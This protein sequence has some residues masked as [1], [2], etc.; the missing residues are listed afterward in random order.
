M[1]LPS[2]I[3]LLAF[4]PSF[5]SIPLGAQDA[6]QSIFGEVVDVRVVNLEVV[7]ENRRGERVEG[8]HAEDFELWVDGEAVPIEFFNEVREGRAVDALPSLEGPTSRLSPGEPVG[9]S[10]LVFI[11]DYFNFAKLRNRALDGIRDHLSRMGPEDRMAVVAFDGRKLD[12]LSNWS[13][14]PAH[15]QE[16]FNGARQRRSDAYLVRL[17]L[18]FTGIHPEEIISKLEARVE[19]L[20]QAVT[21]T[22][23]SFANPSGRKVMLLVSGGWPYSPRRYVTRSELVTDYDRGERIYGPIHETANQLGYTLYPIDAPGISS[24]G[25]DVTQRRPNRSFNTVQEEEMDSTLRLIADA[26]GGRPLLDGSRFD[27]LDQVVTDTRSYYGLGFSPA[28]ERNDLRHD[29]RLEVKGRGLRTRY[30]DRFLDFSRE[31]EV[32]FLVES[33]LLLG[34]LPGASPMEVEFL[35]AEKSFRRVQVPAK[36]IFP[37]EELTFLPQEGQYL[38]QLELRIASLDERGYRSELDLLPFEL[39]SSELPRPGDL[40]TQEVTLKLR[41]R[42]HDLI[43]SLHDPLSGT[44]LMKQ[45]GYPKEGGAS[46]R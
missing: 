10:Y 35:A 29:V 32:S 26:T 11:D 3:F 28:W 5:S 30:R 44:I 42:P 25:V 43:F 24:S 34:D 46:G 27:A 45:V 14:S 4:F 1:N 16:V 8:L 12:M 13:Q 33:A 9:T 39:H 19:N 17:R 20:A 6:P 31:K 21:A 40:G 2:A 15:L 22:M 41:R 38:A 18:G 36:V 37:L 23:R 7:V